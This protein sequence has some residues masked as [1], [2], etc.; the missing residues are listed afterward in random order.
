MRTVQRMERP[1]VVRSGV[2][3]EPPSLITKP[4]RAVAGYPATTGWDPGH[5]NRRADVLSAALFAPE[6]L[7]R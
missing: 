6:S 1:R 4:S 2:R 7:E 3:V 5:R